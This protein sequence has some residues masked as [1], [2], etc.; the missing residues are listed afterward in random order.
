MARLIATRLIVANEGR[1]GDDGGEWKVGGE[2][3]A[4]GVGGQGAGPGIRKTLRLRLRLRLVARR[5]GLLKKEGCA[6][7]EPPVCFLFAEH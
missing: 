6:C 1:C 7:A 5:V 2:W 3:W 4:D